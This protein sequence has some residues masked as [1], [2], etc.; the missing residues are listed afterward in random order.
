MKGRMYPPAKY[1]NQHYVFSSPPLGNFI[2]IRQC[3][4]NIL[5]QSSSIYSSWEEFGLP[6]V[7]G[8]VF[9][10]HACHKLYMLAMIRLN[11]AL[12]NSP[13]QQQ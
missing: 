4:A 11:E 7:T 5:C 8:F 3:I 2:I 12:A 6:G 1:V 9:G 10:K 13:Q